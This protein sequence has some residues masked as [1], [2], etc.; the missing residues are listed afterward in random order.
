MDP[1][2]RTARAAG[3]LY[4][5]TFAA[6]FPALALL[7]PVLE[8][9]Y[10]LG[11]G[12]DVRVT[13]GALLDL[14]NAGAA[15]GTAVVLLPVM[16][17][18]GEALA[19]GFVAARTMEAAIIAIGVV[20][21][22]AVVTMRGEVAAGA[23]ATALTTTASALVT[24]RDWT[25]LLGPGLVPGIN[26]LLL[27][28]L[29]YRSGLVPRAIPVIGLVGAPLH[30]LSVLATAYGLNTQLSVASAVAVLPIVAWELSLGLWLTFRGFR[31]VVPDRVRTALAGVKDA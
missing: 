3:L 7:G 24:A 14:V 22:L 29:M 11:S 10:V 19:L 16:R 2:R 20:N 28:T 5:L 8:P 1:D 6:S 4:L 31:P 12:Q 25:F 26:A 30:L 15:I 17:R 18:Y 9:G 27:G 13:T 23:D 21:V